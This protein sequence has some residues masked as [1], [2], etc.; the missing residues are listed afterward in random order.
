MWAHTPDELLPTKEEC[1]RIARANRLLR[2]GSS[3]EAEF[4]ARWSGEGGDYCVYCLAEG[5]KRVRYIG[6]TNQLVAKRLAQHMADRERGQNLHKENWLRSC[7]ARNIKVTIHVV[8]AGLT[9]NQAC[10][11]EELLIKLLKGPF[12]LTNSHS[13]GATGYAG[14]SEESRV[15]HRVNTKVGSE[16]AFEKLAEAFDMER[17]YCLLDEWES[18]DSQEAGNGLRKTTASRP[19]ANCA[20]M[21]TGVASAGDSAIRPNPPWE[22]VL[23]KMIRGQGLSWRTEQSYRNWAVRFAEYIQPLSPVAAGKTEV[24]KFLSHLA[25]EGSSRASQKQAT[26][27]LFMLMQDALRIDLGELEFLQADTHAQE[28]PEILTRPQCAELFAALDEQPRL[29]AELMYC[30]GIRPSELYTIRV[31]QLHFDQNRL[32]IYGGPEGGLVRAMPLPRVLLPAIHEHLGRL[33]ALWERDLQSTSCAGAWV[34][35]ACT[36]KD[37]KAGSK[38]E[39]QWLFPAK[40]KLRDVGSGMQ[41][42]HHF[43]DSRFQQLVKTAAKKAGLSMR[44]SPNVL[45]DSFVRHMLDLG[46]DR[47]TIFG[48]VG[49]RKSSDFL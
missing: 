19:L 21:E 3:P 25:I 2:A 6:I 26:N 41:R 42:R 7:A 48:I 1:V 28:E 32:H 46:V 5:G 17:G 43:G 12:N 45:R 37:P 4:A 49:D 44:V 30:T 31:H 35:L 33:A 18:E 8:R 14:L 13:G 9:A 34:P 27:A 47:R 36:A 15:K 10:W 29:M 23:T 20:D 11:I 40:A 39:W 16:R 22:H 24:E 38:W